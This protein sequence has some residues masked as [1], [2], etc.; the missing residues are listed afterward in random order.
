[1]GRGY[2]DFSTL[3]SMKKMIRSNRAA[4]ARYE[5]AAFICLTMVVAGCKKEASP[6]AEKALVRT[7]LVQPIANLGSD[8]EASCLAQVRAEKETDLSFKLGGIVEQIGPAAG[9]DWDEG[10]PVKA[11]Q[12]LA[13]LKQQDFI[14][15]R[16]VARGR[17]DLS[18]K[19]LE[20]DRQ[21]LAKRV[22]SPEEFDT[23]E[24]DW[25]T[26][27]AMLDEAGHGDDLI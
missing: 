7:T 11:G 3:T 25:E 1:M 10:T 16:N 18:G 8:G 21:L 4:T 24:G 9:T 13:Q 12:V 19:T 15:V 27:K 14:N 6:P 23:A 22:I 5:L 26:S 17:A 20:R 2:R